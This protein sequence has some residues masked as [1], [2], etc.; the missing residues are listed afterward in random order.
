MIVAELTV[1][2]EVPVDVSVSDCVVA[3]FTVTLPKL[4]L[5]AL[6]V[7]CGLGAA[8][9]VPLRVTWAE[10]PV[11]EL[12][13]IVIWPLPVP[14]DVGRY[15][16]CSV[17]DCIGFSATGKLLPPV[18]VKPVPLI[19][20]ELTVTGD[21]PDDVSVKD[22]VVAVFTVTL[23]KLKLVA[24]TVNC[25]LGAA[26]PVPPSATVVVL[27]VDELLLI[28]IWPLADPVAVGSN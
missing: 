16:T 13:L 25:G 11:D 20:T 12:L 19:V 17:S 18:I 14:V 26:V 2:G 15:C 10:D 8:T 7:N 21:V 5:A 1:T 23:P 4:R 9:L 27:P 28:V 6:S 24:L 22:C 3:V